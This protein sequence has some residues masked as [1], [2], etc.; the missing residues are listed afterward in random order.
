MRRALTGAFIAAVAAAV[1]APAA[2]G[3]MLIS[4]DSRNVRLTV[5]GDGRSAIVTYEERGIT[6]NILASGA[7]NAIFPDPNVP[8]VSFKLRYVRQNVGAPGGGCLEYDGPPLPWLVAACKAQDGSYWAAQRW[9]RNLPNYGVQPR[10]TQAG[11]EL[12][13][14]H[15]RG[16]L[17]SFVV[18]QDWAYRRYHHLYGSLRYL[19]RPMHGFRTTRFGRPLDS[20]GVLIYVDTFDS[21]YGRGWHRENS[22]VVHKPKGIFCYGF[23][24]HGPHPAGTGKWYRATAL[25]PGVLPD[26][27]WSAPAPGKYDPELDKRANEEQKRF[28]SDRLCRPN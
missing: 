25:G 1:A 19:G 18:K 9:Q 13:L 6:W 21:T 23:F 15:W 20:H 7:I 5:V 2:R 10:G 27:M 4:Q 14:S 17:Q 26:V 12:R 28:Y 8:Q 3:S 22:F 11:W 16:P 24:P